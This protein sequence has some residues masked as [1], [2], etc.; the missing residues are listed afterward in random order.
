MGIGIRV[1][2]RVLLAFLALILRGPQADGST[3]VYVACADALVEKL[4]TETQSTES[5]FRLWKGWVYDLTQL[6]PIY[7]EDFLKKLR[8]KW[9]TS[10]HLEPLEKEFA[11][12]KIRV[13]LRVFQTADDTPHAI[14]VAVFLRE[15]KMVGSAL[16]KFFL[17]D[18]K[19][20]ME[21]SAIAFDKVSNTTPGLAK[22]VIEFFRKQMGEKIGVDYTTAIADYF[23]R[24]VW[25]KMPSV[26]LTETEPNDTPWT[27]LDTNG[28]TRGAW[29]QIKTNFAR[30]LQFHAI[31]LSD[32]EV[33]KNGTWISLENTSQLETISELASVRSRSEKTIPME[34]L[35][36]ILK[37]DKSF[38]GTSKNF[39]VGAAFMVSDYTQF[40]G[41]GVKAFWDFE[42][43]PYSMPP[44]RVLFK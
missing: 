33:Q 22:K 36:G 32:L 17:N 25:A 27:F 40:E 3:P 35:M 11:D 28:D 14:V 30:F 18:E 34:P 10:A 31:A 29:E 37:E 19:I 39:H 24:Y 6:L 2:L 9:G 5:G 41:K 43:S 8:W 38:L 1:Y 21:L 42:L 4:L 44:Y 20:W 12:E 15:E 26:Y 16:S 7:S 13:K 23:G